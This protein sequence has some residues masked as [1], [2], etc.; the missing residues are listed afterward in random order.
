MKITAQK[1]FLLVTVWVMSVFLSSCAARPVDYSRVSVVRV[2]DGDTIQIES[3]E[4]VRLIG[5]DCPEVGDSDKLYRQAEQL[6]MDVRSVREMAQKAAGFTSTLVYGRQ[7]RLELDA[8]QYDKYSR[9]L[10]YVFLPDGAMLNEL[11][12][13]K[14]YALLLTIPP[15]VKY[16]QRFKEALAE[17][18]LNEQ[19]LWGY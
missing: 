17:A 8:E 3:G 18:Q 2:I 13:R 15:N 4:E 19:G 11:I 14:G 10:A 16:Q 12:V 7:I 6:H 1:T 9:L 5:I